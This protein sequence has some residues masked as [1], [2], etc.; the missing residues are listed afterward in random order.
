MIKP[1]FTVAVTV[2]TIENH[3][4]YWAEVYVDGV[5]FCNPVR[6]AAGGELFVTVSLSPGEHTFEVPASESVSS[7]GTTTRWQGCVKKLTLPPAEQIDGAIALRMVLH[8]DDG[9]TDL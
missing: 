7:G 9:G 3:R 5:F 6:D 4:A 8:P 2:V 1:K